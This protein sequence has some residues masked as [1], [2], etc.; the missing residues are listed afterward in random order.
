MRV[1]PTQS[2]AARRTGAA[3]VLV[4]E[5]AFHGA[6]LLQWSGASASPGCIFPL[7]TVSGKGT[8]GQGRRGLLVAKSGE[9]RRYI[10]GR[11]EKCGFLSSRH[12]VPHGLKKTM[13]AQDALTSLAPQAWVAD[14]VIVLYWQ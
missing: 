13:S 10:R 4:T 3:G 12:P 6:S 14:Q 2:P 11:S 8:G 5:P 7:E 9:R 1:L